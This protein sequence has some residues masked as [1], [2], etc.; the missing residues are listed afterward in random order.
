MAHAVGMTTSALLELGGGRSLLVN[1]TY[2]IWGL[3]YLLSFYTPFQG[4][5]RADICTFP[6]RQPG[7]QE[8]G[9][10]VENDSPGI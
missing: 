1:R 9:T 3:A 7:G 10:C 8:R 5:S 6:V 2:A 4:T